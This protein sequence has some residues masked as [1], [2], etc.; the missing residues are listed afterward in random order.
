MD[1]NLTWKHY[2]DY[3]ASKISKIIGIIA[4]LRHFVPLSTLLT[5]YQS[6]VFP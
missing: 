5:I 2:V 1:G 6:L 3:I 4:R